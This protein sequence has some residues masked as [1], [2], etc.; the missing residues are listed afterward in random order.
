MGLLNLS[1]GRQTLL[2]GIQRR[3]QAITLNNQ[4]AATSEA[5]KIDPF[6]AKATW[7]GDYLN[8]SDTQEKYP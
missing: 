2:Y 7:T 3:M 5:Y 6:I 4:G 1:V 8:P